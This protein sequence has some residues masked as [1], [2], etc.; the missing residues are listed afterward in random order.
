MLRELHVKDYALIEDLT[1]EF[2][3][4]LNLLTGETGAGKSILIG[5]LG[6]LLGEKGDTD[7]IRTGADK[8]TVEGVF[9]MT[10]GLESSFKEI[11]SLELDS[12]RTLFLK[13]VFHRN[14]R[15]QSYLNE[16]P[17]P[18]SLSRKIG[19]HLLDIHGQHEHQT[20]L[21]VESHLLYL[22]SY[23]HLLEEREEVRSLFHQREKIREEI[24]EKERRWRELKEREELLRFQL[25]EILKS[26]IEEKEDLLLEREKGILENSETLKSSTEEIRERL[27]DGE[28]AIGEHLGRIQNLLEKIVDLDP[29]LK[30]TLETT[31]T[32]TYQV[33]DLWRTLVDYGKKVEFD[34]DRLERVNDRLD[35]LNHLKKKYG[36]SSG[37]LEGVIETKKKMERE[38]NTLEQGEDETKSLHERLKEIEKDLVRKS[39]DL[40]GKRE[41]GAKDL[42]SKMELEMRKLGMEGSSFSIWFQ[43]LDNPEDLM[44]WDGKR[45]GVKEDGMDRIEFLL[46]TN[47]GEGLKPLR[48]I[49]SGGEIS[50]IMLA[51]KGL[52]VDNIPTLIFDEVDVGIGGKMAEVIGD[53]LVTLAMKKQ[54]LCITH[55]PQIAVQGDLHYQVIKKKKG[56]RT[57][58]EIVPLRG[59]ERRR[60]I[61]RMLGGPKP[62]AL[63]HA[64]EMLRKFKM[65]S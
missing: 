43:R 63:Q 5:A 53:K 49:A 32:I 65:K 55:L 6:F 50:R 16:S 31:K 45:F 7:L 57:T 42:E 37:G 3:K 21:N 36:F 24:R 2:E 47:L 56:G 26:G 14:G 13:R 34:P 30:E 48:K 15:S 4:G 41:K 44:E 1:I 27:M 25:D 52:L 62:I 64:E 54:I 18:L 12:E 23:S 20:L 51:L 35:L 40:S 46:S 11:P 38:L 61:A 8:V 9:E 10:R 59:E 60:E 39:L 19:E 22:D 33:E 29:S 17:I 58:T 28:G